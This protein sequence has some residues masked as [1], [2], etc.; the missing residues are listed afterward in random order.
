M[1]VLMKTVDLDCGH[2]DIAMVRK[3]LKKNRGPDCRLVKTDIG[4]PAAGHVTSRCRR[5]EHLY[6]REISW[7]PTPPTAD[8]NLLGYRVYVKYYKTGD[9]ACFRL[10]PSATSFD[11]N[12]SVGF[13]PGCRFLYSVT[14][15]PISH[16]DTVSQSTLYLAQS[17]PVEIKI[18]P[19]PNAYVQPFSTYK[20]TAIFEEVPTPAANITWYFSSDRTSCTNPRPIQEDIHQVE[21]SKDDTVLTILRSSRQH[22]GCYIVVADNGIGGPRL[23]RGYLYLNETTLMRMPAKDPISDVEIGLF[24]FLACLM[25]VLLMAGFILTRKQNTPTQGT[26]QVEKPSRSRV[27]ISHCMEEKDILLNFLNSM[28]SCGFDVILDICNLVEINNSGG[29]L[30]WIQMNMATADK[31]II[32]ATSRLLSELQTSTHCE[33]ELSKKLRLEMKLL[34]DMYNEDMVRSSKITVLL[35]N[36]KENE[37]VLP[38]KNFKTV[39]FTENRIKTQFFNFESIVD[40]L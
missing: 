37:L 27:Y 34:T 29:I 17:C 9:F 23:Q 20:F 14:P 10:P 28:E 24:A 12:K 1:A 2:R 39:S 3:I 19:L 21:L 18:E 11:F 4:L 22:V 15:L 38:L 30:R 5:D 35:W 40:V 8:I 31:I 36:V 25:A 33:N 32:I 13:A 16:V 7:K 6:Y 26:L